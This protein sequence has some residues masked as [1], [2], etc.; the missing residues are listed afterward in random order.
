MFQQKKSK[1]PAVKPTVSVLIPVKN[2]ENY[3]HKCLASL[4]KQTFKKF[5][6]ILVNNNSTDC[7]IQIARKFNKK[8]KLKIFVCTRNGVGQALKYGLTR[9][10]GQYICRLDCD[11]YVHKNRITEQ[12]QVLEKNPNIAVVSSNIMKVN[13]K[14]KIIEKKK[15]FQSNFLIKAA[16]NYYNPIFHP[17]CMI[18]KQVINK[19]GG[20]ASCAEVVEDYDLW[21]R[22]KRTKYKF[23]NIAK[24]LV[25]Y[26]IHG[27]SETQIKPKAF[28]Q[29][30]LN[31]RKIA[32]KKG[33]ISFVPW[34]IG[35]VLLKI[36]YLWK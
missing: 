36:V 16:L 17:S 1:I 8:L 25:F 29:R 5:E 11:D 21:L 6:V 2:G 34:I 31:T 26:R 24:P 9:C 10:Q 30:I 33:S 15:C 19:V 7:S 13:N 3:L 35:N 18:R 4:T 22:I 14:N 12:I 32:Y 20:Y 23:A 27:H 28:L